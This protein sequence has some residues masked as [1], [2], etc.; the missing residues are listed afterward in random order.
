MT[1]AAGPNGEIESDGDE[2]DGLCPVR[3]RGFR[4]LESEG[5]EAEIWLHD[6]LDLPTGSKRRYRT[7]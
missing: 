2:D 4:G 1:Y 6:D 5:D 3:G 7:N